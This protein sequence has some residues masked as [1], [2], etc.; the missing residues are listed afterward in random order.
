MRVLKIL[1]GSE[2]V[3]GVQCVCEDV[4]TADH[5]GGVN[6]CKH[7]AETTENQRLDEHQRPSDR[8][9]DLTKQ[10]DPVSNQ[11]GQL[12]EQTTDQQKAAG[13]EE[14]ARGR[15]KHELRR[16]R[17]EEAATKTSIIN[18]INQHVL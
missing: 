9:G 11:S 6:S 3:P 7:T 13:S 17:R 4:Q 16:V 12:T 18:Q 1:T 14:T 10:R 8:R 2:V 5:S 15:E